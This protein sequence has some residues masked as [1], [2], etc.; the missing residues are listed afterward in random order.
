MIRTVYLRIQIITSLSKHAFCLI[1]TVVLK[2]PDVVC[3]IS[4][5]STLSRVAASL[6]EID[7]TPFRL[8]AVIVAR[9]LSAKVL[10]HSCI[11]LIS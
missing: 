11:N 2:P 1:S 8:R 6:A 9:V 5:M 4:K 3:P 7:M 10:H